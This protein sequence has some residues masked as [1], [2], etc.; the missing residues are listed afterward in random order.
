MPGGVGAQRDG[1]GGV[2]AA[3]DAAGGDDGLEAGPRLLGDERPPPPWGPPT[4]AAPC[5]ATRAPGAAR[6]VSTATHEVPPAPETSMCR[7]P[8]RAIRRA[9]RGPMPQPVSLATTGTR[10][11]LGEPL[12]G[13]ERAGEVAIAPGL[14]DLLGGVQVDAERVGAHARR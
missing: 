7:T 9:A 5:P 14:H 12:H 4:R 2:E 3:R 1:L 11:L 13:A 6:S 10:E 8:A